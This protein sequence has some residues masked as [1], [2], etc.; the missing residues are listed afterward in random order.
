MNI[1][2]Q[3]RAKNW[4]QGTIVDPAF[5][6]A[7]FDL[8]QEALDADDRLVVISQ[9]CDLLQ[10][11]DAAEPEV[12]LLILYRIEALNGN[13]TNNKH[14]RRIHIQSH[15]GGGPLPYSATQQG[16]VRIPRSQL[17]DWNPAAYEFLERNQI[18]NL[19]RWLAARYVRAAFPDQFEENIRS[20]K[21]H[22]RKLRKLAKKISADV[23]GIYLN[24]SPFR[25]LEEGEQYSVELLALVLP[26]QPED[27]PEI[28]TPMKDMEGLFRAAGIDVQ[29]SIRAEN[30]VPYSMFRNDFKP[31]DFDS[32]SLN[33]DPP[34]ELP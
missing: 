4:R 7:A 16:K 17:L 6:K 13:F 11:D 9:S 22:D 24:L 21:G 26:G 5:N 25:D 20:V 32:I 34:H 14:P 29:M 15:S 2:E 27:A 28:V 23:T 8:I 31:W 33:Q 3:L 10:I 18:S 19:A 12:E 1:G 30:K